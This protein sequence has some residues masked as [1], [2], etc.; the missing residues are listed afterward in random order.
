MCFSFLKKKPPPPLMPEGLPDWVTHP[1][2]EV[3]EEEIRAAEIHYTY[4]ELLAEDRAK[5]VPYGDENWHWHWYDYHIEAAW[6]TDPEY[7]WQRLEGIA[8]L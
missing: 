7:T 6:H 3:A 8:A 5:W 1:R 2:A 4:L